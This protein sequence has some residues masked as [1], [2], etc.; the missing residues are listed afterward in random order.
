MAVLFCTA[1]CCIAVWCTALCSVVM[2]YVLLCCVMLPS[3]AA[4]RLFPERRQYN[5]NSSPSNTFLYNSVTPGYTDV[6]S[7]LY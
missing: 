5:Y 2:Y 6:T 7:V 3:G 4:A 1:L